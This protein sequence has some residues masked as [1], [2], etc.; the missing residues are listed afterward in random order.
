MNNNLP[1]IEKY[2]PKKLEDLVLNEIILKQL[3]DFVIN[4]SIPNLIFCGNSG[5]GKSSAINCLIKKIYPKEYINDLVFELNSFDD[6][7]IEINTFIINFAKKKVEFDENISLFK[8]I[9]IEEADNITDKTQK[10]ISS[11]FDKY[12]NTKFIFTCNNTN[13]IIEC[14][15]SRCSIICF[16]EIPEKP[17]IK[18]LQY[19]CNCENIENDEDSLLYLFNSS[20]KDIRK[21]IN[22]LELVYY[23]EKKISIEKINNVFN[24]P[25]LQIYKEIYDSIIDE[26]IKNICIIIKKLKNEGYYAFDVLIYFINFL[27]KFD[28]DED[29]KIKLINILSKQTYVMSS[30]SVCNYIQLTGI[31]L[32]CIG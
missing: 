22:N 5:I 30:K 27:I 12:R 20:N 9:I 10:L 19:I 16:T 15:Q 31:L 28:I 26:N 17:L 21:T 7:G 25:S 32:H 2:K 13:D 3:N 8:L 14:I 6:R 24:I 23:T 1:F 18:R 29:I 4:K 11:N